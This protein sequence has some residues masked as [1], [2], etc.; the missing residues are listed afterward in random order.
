M[1]QPSKE[2]AMN[3]EPYALNPGVT[4]HTH[5]CGEDG[6]FVNAYLVETSRGVVAIDATLT[7]STSKGLRARLDALR[8]PLLAVLITHPH[9]D[10]VAGLA[11]LV[12][13]DATP[14][15]ATADAL[16]L[17][18]Q[19]EAPKRAQWTPVFGDEWVQQWRY[20]NRIVAHGESL[21]LD[22]V[23]YTVHDLGRGG[24]SDANAIWLATP[25]A[26]GA[27]SVAFL[28]D[29][30]FHGVHS[31]LA[32]GGVLDWL[33]NLEQVG[34]LCADCALAFPG[35]GE[36][37][38]VARL[39]EAQRRYLMRYLVELK[40]VA[41]DLPWGARLDEP[42]RARLTQAMREASPG[43][44]LEFLVGLGADAVLD[45]LRATAPTTRESMTRAAA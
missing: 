28:S 14:I 37:G 18:R 1:A 35:H 31:Y 4:V 33:V 41:A 17:M 5:A 23:R 3:F 26:P 24:D 8:K 13:D 11:H 45:E 36:P 25:D 19:L 43:A 15:H 20:P 42:R 16:A 21:R 7:R 30:I 32:D 34:A 40:A 44:G 38:P 39:V 6:I 12:D 22:G 29:L 27:R 2:T 10:H 9:P